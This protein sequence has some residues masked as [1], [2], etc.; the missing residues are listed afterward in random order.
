[1]EYHEKEKD[2]ETFFK[3]RNIDYNPDTGMIAVPAKCKW[4]TNQNKCRLYAWRPES[5]RAYECE[6]LKKMTID[7]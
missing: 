6:T 2:I 4:L 7:S 3:L 1:M 5:C